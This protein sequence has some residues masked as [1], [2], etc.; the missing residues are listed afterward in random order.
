MLESSVSQCLA[1]RVQITQALHKATRQGLTTALAQMAIQL[2]AQPV[3]Q[4]VLL[5][6]VCFFLVHY[7]NAPF[8]L[9]LPLKEQAGHAEAEAAVGQVNRRLL[10]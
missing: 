2:L 3:I 7:L 8:E 9:L 10:R 4:T 6:P 5:S 1:F